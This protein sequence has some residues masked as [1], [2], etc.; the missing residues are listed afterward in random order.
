MIDNDITNAFFLESHSTQ[1]AR[2]HAWAR[3]RRVA[4][5]ALFGA[6]LLRVS[7]STPYTVQLPGVIGGR[8]SLN[9]YCAF[10]SRSGGGKGISDKVAR[11]AWPTDIEVRLPGSGEGISEPFVLRGKE[12]EDNERLNAY[13][14]TANEIDTLTGLASRQGSILLAQ[15]KSAWMGEPIGQ[16]NAS[17]ATS[18]HVKEHDYRLCL[19]VG[20]QPGHAKVIFD[21]ASGGSPQRFWWM[22]TEDANMPRGGGEDPEPLNTS[23][24][25]W[26]FGPDGVAEIVYGLPE[27]EETVIDAHLARQRGQA[28][29]LDGHA[30]LSRCKV[31]ALLAV[32]HQ[33]QA[34][35]QLD[36]DMSEIVMQISDRTRND[37]LEHDRQAARARVRERAIARA[38]GDE[39]YDGRLLEGVRRSILKTLERDGEQAGNVLRSRMGKRDRRDMFDQAI[40]LLV[41]EG[42]VQSIDV[43]RGS[44]YRLWEVQG[45]PRVQGASSQL[46]EGEREVQGEPGNNVTDLDTRR[47]HE[48]H[49]P[50]LSAPKWLENHIAA[51]RGGGHST[52][53][54]F[55]VLAE[56]QAAGYTAEA[57]RSAA[58]KNPDVKVIK[59][60]PRT[61]VWDITGNRPTTFRPAIEWVDTYIRRL[62]EGSTVVDREDLRAAAEQ[63]GYSWTAV[64]HAALNHQ[65]VESAPAEGDSTVK[66][67]WIL[68]PPSDPAEGE[69]S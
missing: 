43:E 53:E 60:T 35:N 8:V 20:A 45:E 36:W 6:I 7:A 44:R 13:I 62:P 46:G 68:K 65:R 18:R 38:V 61:S 1:L 26:T 25:A 57:L 2:I 24:P 64:R 42:L 48:I 27:I 39:V 54:S 17:K 12:S 47:S 3:A 11:L 55:A 40:A 33:R 19:S 10:V 14:L 69:A 5:W 41:N 37:L 50:T 34:V 31:A 15:L 16:S 58:S 4:P 52:A 22:P 28:D 30:L 66:R 49:K 23:R 63:A 56:G 51:L 67:V 59:R 21:D 32:M 29:A 9:A